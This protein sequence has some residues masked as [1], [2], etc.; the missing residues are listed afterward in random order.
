MWRPWGK[1]TKDANTQVP[2]SYKKVVKQILQLKI[3]YLYV[4]LSIDR[5]INLY[6][7]ISISICMHTYIKYL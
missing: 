3:N 1:E 2:K 4:Y 7:C 5:S 6:L